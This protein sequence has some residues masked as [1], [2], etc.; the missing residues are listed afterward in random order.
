VIERRF[1]I[2]VLRHV[3]SRYDRYVHNPATACFA[4]VWGLLSPVPESTIMNAEV[5]GIDIESDFVFIGV[6]INKIPFP[7]QHLK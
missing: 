6:V 5:P 1:A 7:E 4:K 3:F 2:L